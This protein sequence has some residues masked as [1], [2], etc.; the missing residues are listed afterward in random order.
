MAEQR[1]LKAEHI[2]EI[3]V[4]EGNQVWVNVDEQCVLR[5][6]GAPDVAIIDDRLNNLTE[7]LFALLRGV[8]MKCDEAVL[9]PHSDWALELA[10]AKLERMTQL[11]SGLRHARREQRHPKVT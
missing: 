9:L 7:P 2:V 8:R 5:V 3:R 1:D 10:A 11:V 6:A 4:G